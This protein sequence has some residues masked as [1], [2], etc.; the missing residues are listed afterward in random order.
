M[1][2]E[3]RHILPTGRKCHAVAMRGKAFCYFHMLDKR[4]PARKRATAA[5]KKQPAEDS[6]LLP[7]ALDRTTV[8][9]AVSRILQAL[10]A[11]RIATRRGSALLYGL[12]LAQQQFPSR[13]ASRNDGLC[14][15]PTDSTGELDLKRL[16]PQALFAI[17]GLIR[18]MMPPPSASGPQGHPGAESSSG[19]SAQP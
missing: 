8:N 16:S 13:P 12:Q 19:R 3:C 15:L 17:E 6:L 5:K 14:D 10:A 4:A 2:P 1:I 7:K 18:K 9:T 11:G